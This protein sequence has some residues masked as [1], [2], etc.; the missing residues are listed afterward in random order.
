MKKLIRLF[1][2]LTFVAFTAALSFTA[3][4][5]DDDENDDEETI[6]SSGTATVDGE[7]YTFSQGVLESAGEYN[8]V[9]V[10]AVML[11]S[12][13]LDYATYSG[14]GEALYLQVNTNSSTFD[15][16]SFTIG[17]TMEANVIDSA[18][19]A[20]G[21]EL[22][23]KPDGSITTA[24]TYVPTPGGTVN[25]S[26][27]GSVYDIDYNLP[28]VQIENEQI[29]GQATITGSYSGELKEGS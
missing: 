26:K 1:S 27:S 16:G 13:G 23:P 28:C 3:C 7:T 8:G 6:T 18:V 12:E 21:L 4:S 2:I 9:N 25:I 20:V 15:G 11:A 29:I 24:K 10:Y 14:T 17:T 5:D 22:P 19:F